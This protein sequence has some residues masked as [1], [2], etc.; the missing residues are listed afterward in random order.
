[1]LGT[2]YFA[3]RYS[4]L[5][6][7][8]ARAV[9]VAILLLLVLELASGLGSFLFGEP[10]GRWLFWLHRTGG[11]SL[12]LLLVWKASIATRSYRRRGLGGSTGLSALASLLFLGSLLTGLLWAVGGLERVSVPVVGSWTVLSLHVALSLLLIPLFLAHLVLRWPRSG[13]ADLLGRRAAL[14]MLGLLAVGLAVLGAQEFLSALAAP[15]GSNR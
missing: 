4:K 5:A 15:P 10:D 1:M 3:A 14:R 11:L 8:N 7:M 12:V 13:R 6:V 2:H 9:N